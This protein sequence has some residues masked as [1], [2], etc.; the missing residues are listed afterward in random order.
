MRRPPDGDRRRRLGL[1]PLLVAAFQH[2]RVEMRL[3]GLYEDGGFVFCTR[4]GTPMTLSN[5]RR[6]F[7]RLRAPGLGSPWT[8][9]EP[10]HSF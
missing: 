9:Y 6:A 10:R 1:H 5:L 4:N 2:H 7:Q 3:L 8:A